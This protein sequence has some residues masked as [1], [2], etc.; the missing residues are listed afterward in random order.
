M[1]LKKIVK[2]IQ[3]VKGENISIIDLKYKNNFICDYFVVCNGNSRNQV[4]AISQSVEKI[5]KNELETKPWHIEGLRNKEWILVDYI[6][7]VVHIF[8]EKK[9]YYYDIE[10]LWK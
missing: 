9:R 6:T 2:G 4:H 8:I 3:L 10:N 7:I 5:I 1:L